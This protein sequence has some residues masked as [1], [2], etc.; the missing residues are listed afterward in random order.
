MQCVSH[1]LTSSETRLH[2]CQILV[3]RVAHRG[4]YRPFSISRAMVS[5]Q[6]QPLSNMLTLAELSIATHLNDK[7]VPPHARAALKAQGLDIDNFTPMTKDEMI[8]RLD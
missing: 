2:V 1:S 7:L 8:A 3:I 6:Y 4:S 5:N